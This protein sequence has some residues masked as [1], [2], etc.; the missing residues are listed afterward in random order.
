[1]LSLVHIL[2]LS[3]WRLWTNTTLFSISTRLRAAGKD[4]YSTHTP[5]RGEDPGERIIY[6]VRE[7]LLDTLQL[8]EYQTLI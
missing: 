3:P 6:N 5:L 1:M 8:H 2:R 4:S 7:G